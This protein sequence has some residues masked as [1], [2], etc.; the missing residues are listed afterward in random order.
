[1]M[2]RKRK[3]CQSD[4]RDGSLAVVIHYGFLGFLGSAKHEQDDVAYAYAAE[5]D[6]SNGLLLA[7]SSSGS[8]NPVTDH[9]SFHRRRFLSANSPRQAIDFLHPDSSSA[10]TACLR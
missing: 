4:A 9:V 6:T 8:R 7:S 1:M 10:K 2:T 3:K 5:C